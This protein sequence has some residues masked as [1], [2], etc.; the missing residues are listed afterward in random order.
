MSGNNFSGTFRNVPEKLLHTICHVS[1]LLEHSIKMEHAIC[2]VPIFPEH[3][4][5][6][7]RTCHVPRIQENART[8]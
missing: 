2:H 3:S 5:G 7:P 4:I 1:I 8:T 6:I